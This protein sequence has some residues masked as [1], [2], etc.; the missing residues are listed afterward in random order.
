[1]VAKLKIVGH[2]LG[3]QGMRTR[4]PTVFNGVGDEYSQEFNVNLVP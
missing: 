2:S 1:M 3:N 4:F